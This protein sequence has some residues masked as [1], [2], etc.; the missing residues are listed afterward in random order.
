M[1]TLRRIFSLVMIAFAGFALVSCDT[2]KPLDPSTFDEYAN[3]I[4]ELYLEGDEMSVNYLFV[5]PEQFGFE[6]Y[7]PK[8]PVPSTYTDE[9]YAE[10]MELL[11][12]FQ[13]YDYEQ[14]SFD[15]KMTYNIIEDL[16]KSMS[17]DIK[18]SE[19]M[20][21][22]YL[23][24]YL[25]Y[26]AQL[27]L[28]LNQ[29]HLRSK[30]DVD[31]YFKYLDDVPAAFKAY[32][33]YEIEKAEHGY[34]M[35]DFV[36]SKVTG[37]CKSF[38]EGID[39][40]ENLHFMITTTN[41][42]IDSLDF[43]TDEEKEYYKEL[44]I[45]KVRG[46]LAEG[47]RYVQ[48][49]LNQVWGKATNKGGLGNYFTEDDEN[50]GQQYY[51]AMFQDT[52]GYDL[53]M[54]DMLKYVT[55]K[56]GQ[57]YTEL[58]DIYDKLGSGEMNELGTL[59]LMEGEVRD[60]VYYFRD[61]LDRY[62]PAIDTSF[63]LEIAYVDPAMED[64]FSPAAY[65]TSAIDDHENEFIILNRG[66]IY[67]EVEDEEGN[68]VLDE[69]GDPVKELDRSYLYTTLAHEAFPGHL[70][71]N[72]YFKNSD[73]SLLRKVITNSG[74]KEGWANY[75]ESIAYTMYFEDHE[76]Y[77]EYADDYFIAN[78]NF[79]AALY[80]RIDIGIHYEGW[81]IDRTLK[82]MSTYYNVTKNDV[83]EI[84]NQLVEVPTNYPMYFFTY[85]KI[86]DMR[87]YALENGATLKEF[88]TAFL[89]CGPAPLEYVEEYIHETFPKN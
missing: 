73:A 78:M 61:N 25:G 72:V 58:V 34:G 46:P 14:L 6:H 2:N 75:M 40:D 89:D 18:D 83:R 30:L 19:Y 16:Y 85:M 87:D 62:F 5:N 70:Y 9:E 33:D 82:F 21:S 59:E 65:M 81:T 49:N 71:Q 77:S 79:S 27:P 84:Y 24:S 51:E 22:A 28:L 42:T 23:G 44:N 64:Y 55:K 37:Q 26:Q 45:E 50:V 76:G 54:E 39:D 20:G 31:N 63:N 80:T 43:L 7:E 4:V 56:M 17:I 88:H 38:L 68:P 69:N 15:Q 29:Y 32:V 1:K 67:V 3:E 35:P 8:L 60:Q 52:V 41:N 86:L 47:Y 11:G 12:R 13:K 48:E 53:P 74:Y 36:I 57:Y 66:S 10:V